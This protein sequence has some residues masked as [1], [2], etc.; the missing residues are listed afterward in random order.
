[1]TAET[2]KFNRKYDGE[3]LVVGVLISHYPR[4]LELLWSP[5]NNGSVLVLRV[6][7]FSAHHGHIL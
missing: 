3:G 4:G 6:G 2:L 7:P 1:M 5:F